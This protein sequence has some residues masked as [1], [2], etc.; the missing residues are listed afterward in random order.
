MLHSALTKNNE[1]CACHSSA[2]NFDEYSKE[3]ATMGTSMPSDVSDD[4]IYTAALASRAGYDR[5]YYG[6]VKP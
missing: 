1:N 3:W 4:V 2:L 6:T 5:E